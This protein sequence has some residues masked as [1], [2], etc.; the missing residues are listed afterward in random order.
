MFSC[1]IDNET[2]IKGLLTF[3]DYSPVIQQ[4]SKYLS[5]RADSAQPTST[6]ASRLYRCRPRT[7]R[8]QCGSGQ[9]SRPHQ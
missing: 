6:E 5:P 8:R 9:S 3:L 7:G 2:G 4:Y 1:E